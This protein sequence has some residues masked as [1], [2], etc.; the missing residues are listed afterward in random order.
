[1]SLLKFQE[2]VPVDVVTQHPEVVTTVVVVVLLLIL[3]VGQL[4]AYLYKVR[5]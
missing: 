5:H 4:M 1:V 2:L 3:E